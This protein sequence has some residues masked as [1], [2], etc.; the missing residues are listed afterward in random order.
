MNN[1]KIDVSEGNGVNKT[2]KPK[3]KNI[4]HYWYFLDNGFQFQPNVW[5]GRDDLLMMSMNLSD[6]VI[7]NKKSLYY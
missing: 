3:E 1:I 7:L 6:I 5:N 4:C 2:N